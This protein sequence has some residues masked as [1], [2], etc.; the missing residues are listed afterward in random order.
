MENK[1][2]NRPETVGSKEQGG[3][4]G[5]QNVEQKPKKALFSSLKSLFGAAGGKQTDAVKKIAP[6]SIDKPEVVHIPEPLKIEK[7]PALKPIFSSLN[8]PE[9]KVASSHDAGKDVFSEIT[10]KTDQPDKIIDHIVK[11]TEQDGI[12]SILGQQPRK[13]VFVGAELNTPWTFKTVQ[14]LFRLSVFAGVISA[15]Y[16][17]YNLTLEPP[18][19]EDVFADDALLQGFKVLYRKP[20]TKEEII[21]EALAGRP[22]PPK[23]TRHMIPNRIIRLNL[24]LGWLYEDREDA[25]GKLE[26]MVR[27]RA[28]YHNVRRYTEPV[29]VIY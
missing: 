10:A 5:Q 8:K 27:K 19:F 22:L 3:E 9:N 12:S 1:N 20:Y 7:S 25:K 28:V 21:S 13:R 29:I 16:F 2:D 17:Y 26:D 4:S 23:S 14:L 18:Y 6:V 24:P 15:G 11:Q